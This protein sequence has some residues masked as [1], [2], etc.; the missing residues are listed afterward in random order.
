MLVFINEIL[1]LFSYKYLLTVYI[2]AYCS[3][4][5]DNKQAI[6]QVSARLG[7]KTF[8]LLSSL[9]HI[10]IFMG[11]KR[12]K[13][14]TK[15]QNNQNAR[16]SSRLS[17]KKDTSIAFVEPGPLEE[18]VENLGILSYIYKFAALLKLKFFRGRVYQ[19]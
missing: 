11:D 18:I 15:V 8:S 3:S 13:K 7:L 9:L 16:T 19:K 12:N 14:K 10:F 1:L 4:V 6:W 17:Q 5:T 2:W